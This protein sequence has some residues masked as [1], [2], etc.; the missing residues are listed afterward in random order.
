MSRPFLQRSLLL[1]PV[2]LLLGGGCSS[3]SPTGPPELRSVLV[4]D[5]A[6]MELDLLAPVDGGS[7]VASPLF[8]IRATFTQLLDGD[9]IEDIL[10]GG[11]V[12]GKSDVATLTWKDAPA[13]APKI[14]A[15]T[16][17]N[18]AGNVGAKMPKPTIFIRAMPGLPSGAKVELKLSRDKITGKGGKPFEGTDTHTVETEPFAATLNVE[19]MDEVTPEFKLQAVLTNAPGEMAAQK[20]KVTGGGMPVTLTVMAD[21]A[22]PRKLNLLPPGEKWTLGWTYVVTLGTDVVDLFGV[23]LAKELSVTFTVVLTPGGDA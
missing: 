7:S 15:V 11:G 4:T 8:P 10:D 22:D 9:K 6:G 20:I 12:Q 3:D 5:P 21:A 16:T 13:G 19:G 18:P 17:Y 2:A 1:L 14:T 23:K